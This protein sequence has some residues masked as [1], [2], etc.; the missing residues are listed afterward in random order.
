MGAEQS[1]HQSEGTIHA[2]HVLR[3]D[4]NSPAAS[5]KLVPYFDYIVSVNGVE[6]VI[7]KI[8][9]DS[10]GPR[11]PK[12]CRRNGKESLGQADENVRL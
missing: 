2:F 6:V 8:S 4:E 12:C 9:F 3:V 1:K 11:N 7:H 10:I 5:A